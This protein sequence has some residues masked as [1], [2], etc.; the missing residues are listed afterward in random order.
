MKVE[1]PEGDPLRRYS[2]SGAP[3]PGRDGALFRFLHTSKRG[4]TGAPD[5]AA[6]R[7]LARRG[8]PRGRVR[9]LAR[10]RSAGALPRAP[11]A[12][13]ALDHAVRTQAGP[14]PRARRRSSRC[15]RSP[16]R[17][18]RAG[19]PARRPFAAGGRITDWVGGTFA[20]VAALAA[21]AARARRRPSA[22]T[23]TSR[24]A[25][26]ANIAGTMYADLFH[27]L[28]GRPVARA[29]RAQRRAAVDRADA[30]RLGRLQHQLAPAVPGLPAADRAQ[31]PAGRRGARAR[32]R[33]LAPHGRVERARARLDHAAH[34]RG[35]RRA[36]GAAADSGRARA[37]RARR[38]RASPTSASAAC[39]LKNPDGDFVQPRPP[40]LMD[41]AGLRPLEPAPRLG[42][43]R[44]S[45]RAAA[46]RR[47][48]A[49]AR[50]SAKRTAA[51]RGH[52][53]ARRHRLV[54]GSVGDRA[55]WPRSAPT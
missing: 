22:S 25:R 7:A 36:R 52:A 33:P 47:E 11:G 46:A 16:A 53:R 15:R 51:A 13:G 32:G 40:Y 39:S 20:A 50:R 41:G 35:D 4:R 37:R 9:R 1:P 14:T 23:S 44:R 3:P 8:R 55:C 19:C 26:S 5:D 24:C 30:R 29:A 28:A 12:G 48:P 34:H 2:A 42:A 49:A 10:A 43:A 38:A 21:R 17:W 54:G 6:V 27:S 18:R 31:R 45:A